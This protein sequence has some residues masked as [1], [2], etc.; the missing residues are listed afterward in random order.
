[1][2][3]YSIFGLVTSFFFVLLDARQCFHCLQSC[4]THG[5]ILSLHHTPSALSSY[6]SLN[7]PLSS[8]VPKRVRTHDLPNL[9][10]TCSS[11][12][13]FSARPFHMTGKHRGGVCFKSKRVS[14][15]KAPLCRDTIALVQVRSLHRAPGTDTYPIGA[16]IDHSR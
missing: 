4:H 11:G 7:S 16:E 9:S 15:R 8:A 2:Y 5:L 6:G 1:M 13:K 12:T 10:T 3:L 14:T